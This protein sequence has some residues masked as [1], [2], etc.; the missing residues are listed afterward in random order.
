MYFLRSL[1]GNYLL[2]LYDRVVGSVSETLTPIQFALPSKHTRSVFDTD[3]LDVLR[4]LYCKINPDYTGDVI[5][6]SVFLKYSSL[7][8][9]SKIYSSSGKRTQVPYIV[10]VQW[11]E[12]LYGSPPTTL[13]ISNQLISHHNDRPCNVH[14]YLKASFIANNKES[15]LLLAYVSWLFPHPQRYRLGKPAQLWCNNMYESF[16]LHSFVQLN[17]ILC[18]C[19]NGI[20]LHDEENV[21]V[22]V[23]LVE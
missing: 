22:V 1:K 16:G 14:Y 12:D 13:P 8:L 7:T 19:A 5:V 17:S 10:H 3:S 15:S 20:R 21:L 2:Y 6:N 23:P 11:N 4:S 18:R 9:N